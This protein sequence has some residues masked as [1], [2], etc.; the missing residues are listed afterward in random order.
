MQVAYK[1][2]IGGIVNG[3]AI[4]NGDKFV[5]VEIANKQVARVNLIANVVDVYSNDEKK[6]NAITLDDSS[7]QIKIKGFSDSSFLLS[8]ISVG[9]TICVIGWVRYYN[10]EIYVIPD[11]VRHVDS[12]WGL[13]RRLELIKIFGEIKKE[14]EEPKENEKIESNSPRNAILEL[15]RKNKDG[16][17]VEQLIMDT[18]FPVEQINSVINSLIESG[19]IYEP[20]PGKIRAL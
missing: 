1:T 11:I 2:W 5:S 10:N 14:K 6:F 18:N 15:I 16:I 3:N 13:I 19:E 12:K 4:F 7:G 8:G 20:M 9:D 17:D